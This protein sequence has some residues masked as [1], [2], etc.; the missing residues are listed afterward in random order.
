MKLNKTLAALALTSSIIL[1]SRCRR[2]SH[3]TRTSNNSRTDPSVRDRVI[4]LIPRE[5]FFAM[6]DLQLPGA[7]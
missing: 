2:S 3:R 5:S 7:K 4:L 6:S 1:P